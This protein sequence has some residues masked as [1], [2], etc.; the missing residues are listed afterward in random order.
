M[1]DLRC[2]FFIV[3]IVLPVT[4]SAQEEKWTLGDCIDHARAN[5]I[6][7]QRQGL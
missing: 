7:L 6:G 4:L 5:N 3:A 2:I 1:K